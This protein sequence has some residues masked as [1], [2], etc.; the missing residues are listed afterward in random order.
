MLKRF[1]G[2]QGLFKLCLIMACCS[3]GIAYGL[4]ESVSWEVANY[5][6]GQQDEQNATKDNSDQNTAARRALLEAA[7]NVS[8]FKIDADSDL[9]KLLLEAI[10][11]LLELRADDCLSKLQQVREENPLFPPGEYIMAALLVSANNA[12]GGIQYLEIAAREY[13]DYPSIYSGFA[14]IAIGQNRFTDAFALASLAVRKLDEGEWN[15]EQRKFFRTEIAD[16]MGDVVIARQQWDE[17]LKYLGELEELLPE[18]GQIRVK[19]AQAY[20]EKGDHEK[21]LEALKQAK[22]LT[23]DLRQPETI[24][25]DWFLVKNQL[26]ESRQWIEKAIADHP[27]D[28]EVFLNYARW[29][30]RMEELPRAAEIA[31]KAEQLGAN[32]YQTAFLKG[33]VAF[34]RRD[35]S[36]AELYFSQLF[37]LQPGDLEASNLLALSLIESGADDKRNRARQL[38]EMN[39]RQ[40]PQNPVLLATLG[41]ILFKS[42][43]VQQSQ[44]IFQ[45]LVSIQPMPATTAYFIAAFLANN[46]DFTNA[47]ILVESALANESYFVYRNA[48]QQLLRQINQSIKESAD[49]EN[50]TDK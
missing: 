28:G 49:Q 12:V 16:V 11:A 29:L 25:A 47:K 26:D 45:Q 30:L 22:S 32:P 15:Q 3:L 50:Q 6:I 43:N 13:S 24:M 17:A 42:D 46:K 7:K 2:S 5:A 33:Q 37:Q 38:A 34:S 10:D 39:A 36:T 48:A 27:N 18:N 35:Y 14:R 21:A 8:P 19:T 44:E 9:E 23:P 31:T 41:W 20:F 4:A 40:F 1:S